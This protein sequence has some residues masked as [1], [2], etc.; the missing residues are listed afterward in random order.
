MTCDRE[1]WRAIVTPH[2]DVQKG[3]F[4][5]SEFAADLWEVHKATLGNAG[6]RRIPGGRFTFY[7]FRYAPRRHSGKQDSSQ[8][9]P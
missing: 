3:T 2:T 7:S 8:Y 6:V 5:S 4:S 1:P 9:E